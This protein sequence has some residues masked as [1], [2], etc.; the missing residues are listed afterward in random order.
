MEA[1]YEFSRRGRRTSE[2]TQP[3]ERIDALIDADEVL[4]DGWTTNAM[5][6]IATADEI[7]SNL[8]NFIV[9]GKL[10]LRPL[11]IQIVHAHVGDFK[12]QRSASAQA[13]RN[14][15]FDHFVLPVN[16]DAPAR[17]CRHVNATPVPKDVEVDSV[18]KE[19]LALKPVPHA[20]PDQ[21]VNCG[22]L[23]NPGAN[24]LDHIVL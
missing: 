1:V 9:L 6:P 17:Q 3:G 12:Q 18:M 13:C 5:K 11:R 10:Y 4:G 15:I 19:T 7:A 14:K 22:L 21:E 16:G 23:Q 2:N 8:V 20:A 24:A